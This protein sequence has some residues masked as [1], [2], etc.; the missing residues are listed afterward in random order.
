MSV[1]SG[2]IGE[3]PTDRPRQL[4]S[5]AGSLLQP[6][7]AA[8]Q[9]DRRPGGA[10]RPAAQG[11]SGLAVTFRRWA[12]S[13]SILQPADVAGA[14]ALEAQVLA[15]L[16]GVA[17]EIGGE[18]VAHWPLKVREWAEKAPV[19]PADLVEAVRQS[20]GCQE[21]PLSLLYEAGISPANRRRLG[22]V[23]TPQLLV[24]Y[25]LDLAAA[26]L[27]EPPACVLDPGAGVGAFTV[28]A[29]KRWPDARI[30]AIDVNV[31]TLGLLAARISF[32]M[33]DP[34]CH[35]G[36][37][38]IELV[39][40]DYLDAVRNF[41]DDAAA[42]TLVLGNPPYT[43]VQELPTRIR[44]KAAEMSSGIVENGH[45]NLAVLFQAATL[46]KM[47]PEDV[48]C[49]VL[50]GSLSYTHSSR[51]LRKT[52]WRSRRA[53]SVSRTRATTRAFAGRS[54]QAAVLLIGAERKKRE[55]MKLA[56]V[57]IKEGSVAVVD[58]WKQSRTGVEPDNWFWTAA[59]SEQR[60]DGRE[61]VALSDFAT[62]RRGVAT[63]ANEMFFLTDAEAEEM[64]E[65]VVVPAIPSLRGFVGES[66][67]V[68]SHQ[69]MGGK[70]ARRWLLSIPADQP[71]T[72]ALGERVRR[73]ED[74]VKDRHLPSRRHPWYS[75]TN[76]FRPQILISP[77]SKS[78][79]RVVLNEMNAVP[80]NNLFGISLVSEGEPN[81]LA[82]WLRSAEGQAAL[83]RISRRYHGGSFK[84][85]PGSL[86]ALKVPK[87]L[88]LAE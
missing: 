53:I 22:T 44:R 78:G 43:R 71:L 61:H 52:L 30:V 65:E 34:E 20:M 74:E 13:A 88:E 35:P 85:E 1:V 81:R 67:D 7:P 10:S 69:E 64:P 56:R 59:D 16:G 75:I 84:L 48:S 80:S 6:M 76:L 42:P 21:D 25:M 17:R 36:L 86:A 47:R 60:S 27:K 12:R 62:V 39:L 38:R 46:A 3:Q 45:A 73:Y 32:E 33:D 18:H 77:L 40:D 14:S 28:A 11:V 51:G 57:E 9:S 72:G 54:V 79:F 50:P 24:D 83:Q 87:S 37:S 5:A 26:E 8:A 31:V 82:A 2:G 4:E 68:A 15:A 29:A 41:F 49:M 58:D 23:F 55:P 70:D 19:P 63:G 66:L